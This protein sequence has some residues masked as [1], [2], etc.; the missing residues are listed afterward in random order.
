MAA[1]RVRSAVRS[2]RTNK[3]LRDLR[4][5]FGVRRDWI[6]YPSVLCKQIQMFAQM[7]NTY[8]MSVKWDD[9]RMGGSCEHLWYIEHVAASHVLDSTLVHCDRVDAADCRSWRC[10][11]HTLCI[12]GKWETNEVVQAGCCWGTAHRHDMITRTA[13]ASYLVNISIQ[14]NPM[15]DWP[16]AHG[17]KTAIFRLERIERE[18]WMS[19][20]SFGTY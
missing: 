11:K 12:I 8:C 14:W 6:M 20:V 16:R 17:S 5:R 18:S 13:H 19:I 1:L 3:I 2:R 15:G 9:N 4:N 10:R 7:Y